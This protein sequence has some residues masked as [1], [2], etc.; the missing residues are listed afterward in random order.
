MFLWAVT[1]LSVLDKNGDTMPLWRRN[2]IARRFWRERERESTVSNIVVNFKGLYKPLLI[3]QFG[4]G[5]K[6]TCITC[7]ASLCTLYLFT[8]NFSSSGVSG[9]RSILAKVSR[10][11]PMR[12]MELLRAMMMTTMKASG[13]GTSHRTSDSDRLKSCTISNC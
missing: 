1:D 5:H 12:R 6:T 3:S 10:T 4:R 2:L 13:T 11:C 8:R 9:G 7:V